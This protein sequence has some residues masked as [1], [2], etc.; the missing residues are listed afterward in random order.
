MTTYFQN[1]IIMI[2]IINFWAGKGLK[3]IMVNIL[4]QQPTNQL[5]LKLLYSFFLIIRITKGIELTSITVISLSLYRFIFWNLNGLLR[6]LISLITTKQYLPHC[7]NIIFFFFYQKNSEFQFFLFLCREQKT[8]FC[9][10][11]TIFIF[12]N[13]FCVKKKKE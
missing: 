2:I 4:T 1:N 9:F 10:K 7:I 12:Q 6:T 5:T 13:I 8:S 11:P 3:I